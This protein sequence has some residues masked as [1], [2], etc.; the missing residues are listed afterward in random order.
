MILMLEI[1]MLIVYGV[2]CF[3]VIKS[4]ERTNKKLRE[5][6]TQFNKKCRSLREEND[7]LRYESATFS[8]E[9]NARNAQIEVLKLEIEAHK[10]TRKELD[11]RLSELKQENLKMSVELQKLNSGTEC[12]SEIE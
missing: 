7:R 8:N 6:N 2:F 9:V 1:I 5:R 12:H 11:L 10:L 3:V 4:A